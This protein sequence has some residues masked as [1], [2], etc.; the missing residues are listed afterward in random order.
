ML[1]PELSSFL[2][3]VRYTSLHPWTPLY[4]HSRLSLSHSI[5][6]GSAPTLK[7]DTRCIEVP[8]GGCAYFG[9][10]IPSE[11]YKGAKSVIG[12]VGA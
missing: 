2:E 3:L 1:R 11:A 9:G 6:Q 12:A 4:V 7:G 10:A 5:R 8:N